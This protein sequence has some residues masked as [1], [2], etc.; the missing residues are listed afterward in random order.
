MTAS[1]LAVLAALLVAA[2]APAQG[3]Y[4]PDTPEPGSV[5]KIAEYTTAPEYLPSSVAYVP[6]SDTV[7]SPGDVL[8]RIVG[9]PGELNT[10]AQIHGYYRRLAEASP[11]VMVETIG[12]SVEGRDILLAIVSSEENL[13]RLD[14]YTD[15]TS[16]LSDPRTTDRAAME[17]LVAEGKVFYHFLGGLHS[18]ETGPSEMLM[19][20]AYRLAVSEKPELKSIRDNVVTLITP[21]MEPDGRDR[22]VEW[23]YRHLRGRDL[24]YR[25]LDR[26]SS[27]PYWGHYAFHDN[28]R[29]GMQLTLPLTRAVNDAYWR[30]HPQVIHDLHESLPLL[31][32]STGH[33][34]YSLA[35]DPV[36]INE[37]T[38]FA[39][40]EASELQAQDL[41][42]V[43]TWG[44]WDGWWPGYLF[45]VANNHNST[46]R[47]YETFGNSLAGTFERDLEEVK[48]VGKPVTE[49]QW[50]RPW[51]PDTTL[52][53]SLRN[54]TNYMQAGVLEALSYAALHREELLRN[55]W[56]KGERAVEKGKR[57]APYAW[58]FPLEQRDVG[59][60]AYLVNQLRKHRIEVHRLSMAA[61]VDDGT[62]PAGTVVVR[63]D[64][65][66]R[67]AAMNFLSDQKFPAGEPNPPYDD[68]AWTWPLLFGVSGTA[69][70]DARILQAPMDP[71]TEP[72]RG[73]GAVNGEGPVYLLKD[74]GQT[75]LLSARILLGTNRVDAV[76]ASF[77][78]GTDVYP[79]GSWVVRASRSAVERVAEAFG[80]VFTAA[81]EPPD[82]PAHALDLPKLAVYHTWIATQDCGWVRYTLDEGDV[83]YTLISDEDLKRGNLHSRFDVILFPRTWGD[84]ADIVHGIDPKYGPLPYTKTKAYP[85][86]GIPNASPDITGGMGFAGL[87]NLQEFIAGGGTLV[88]MSSAGIL[89]VDGGLV[90]NVRR[91]D[92]GRTPGSVFRGKVLRSEHPVA[93]GYEE[94]TTVFR[95]NGPLFDVDKEDRARVIVQF[96]TKEVGDTDGDAGENTLMGGAAKPS[97]RP[98]MA[99]NDEAGEAEPPSEDKEK[100]KDGPLV[101]SG[102]VKANGGDT[103]EALD[104]KP[105]ILDLPTGK[106]RVILFSFNPMHRYLNHADFRYV[107]NIILNWNDLPRE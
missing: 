60:W 84:L 91:V 67:G 36:T 105:A 89:P 64:Q 87:A 35:V 90:R 68:V 13:A 76:E 21:V 77:E 22:V 38:Q 102:F 10:V 44:F 63:M 37:W 59:R 54:N 100:E 34:P 96:G 78:R 106:G 88:A 43:W 92:P 2:P 107:Y 41:P 81:D 6:D 7:P 25:E 49:V 83:P 66:Y 5:E 23:Q 48:F 12:T 101:L 93:Y 17:R 80:L 99:S 45:S 24:P 31:Y 14:R 32:I 69:V 94:K 40:H 33:G 75:S 55:F 97:I 4:D 74:E 79:P 52:T 20:L 56:V 70:K 8:G 95:G 65:P 1:P 51:P 71:V 9:T 104:G 30:Y 86:H 27:P 29:D 62:W 46:G 61:T 16:R 15:I 39:H 3:P 42:G 58:V 73:Q 18:T 72:V 53:W 47:F 103:R 85:S 26:F 50:Y 28:N 82:V 98:G 11:R 19:E 57:E